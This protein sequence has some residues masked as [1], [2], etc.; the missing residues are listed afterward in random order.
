LLRQ[1]AVSL[2]GGLVTSI[3][4][5]GTFYGAA[6]ANNGLRSAN[7]SIF[8]LIVLLAALLLGR[9]GAVSFTV[10]SLIALGWFY[11]FDQ[12]TL[13][14]HTDPLPFDRILIPALVLIV[15]A[16]ALDLTVRSVSDSLTRARRDEHELAAANEELKRF[17]TALEERVIER[18]RKLALV[19]NIGEKLS[20]LVTLADY[21]DDMVESVR[22]NFGY[23]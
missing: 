19:T 22:E 3:L 10:L 13:A 20:D 7:T 17:N 18:T 8:V 2:S 15:T 6:L 21:L 11:R 23:Y 4:Y 9:R 12:P 5:L 1:G 16:V 14:I